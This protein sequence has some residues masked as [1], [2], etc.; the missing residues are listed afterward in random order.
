MSG[1]PS[2]EKIDEK[3]KLS[4]EELKERVA[5]VKRFRELLRSQRDRFQTYL[6]TLDRQKAVIEKGSAEDI[7]THVE[8]EEKI[9]SD[10][11]S[12]QKTITPLEAMYRTGPVPNAPDVPEIQAA[13]SSLRAKA[14]I[15]VQQ[16]KELLEQRM[17]ELREELKVIK[18][19]P[20]AKRIAFFSNTDSASFVDING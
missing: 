6:E 7:L 14:G 5:I 20:Y 13:L 3:T 15:M 8:M 17:A 12:I 11:F 19:N 10:I 18:A 16:N 4:T 1:E 9:L 2:F